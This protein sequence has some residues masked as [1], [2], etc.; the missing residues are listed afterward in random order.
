MTPFIFSPTLPDN[1]T[2]SMSYKPFKIQDQSE[3]QNILCQDLYTIFS[4]TIAGGATK[5]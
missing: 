5:V 3:C 4:H 2:K 1:S